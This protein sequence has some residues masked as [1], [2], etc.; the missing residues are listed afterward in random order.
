MSANNVKGSAEKQS[1]YRGVSWHRTEKRWISRYTED[2][3]SHVLGMFKCPHKAAIARSEFIIELEQ[4]KIR[5][6][7]RQAAQE[8]SQSQ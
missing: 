8:V 2:G 1:G 5:S 7:A 4:D 3:R 6:A